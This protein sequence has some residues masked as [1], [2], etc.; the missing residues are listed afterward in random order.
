[1]TIPCSS[2]P[3][4]ASTPPRG[5]VQFGI[6]EG[7]AMS[8]MFVAVVL[9]LAVLAV[10]SLRAVAGPPQEVSGKMALDEVEDGLRRYRKETDER[11]RIKWLRKLA[12][13]RDPRVAVALGEA[14]YDRSEVVM[15]AAATAFFQEFTQFRGTGVMPFNPAGRKEWALMWWKKNEPE[16]R[17]RAAQL[18]R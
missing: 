10:D 17:C 7:F 18:P 3:R 8:R 13:S 6:E 15:A 12:P 14:M 4:S 9:P 5:R 1:V 11:K 16:L 2:V